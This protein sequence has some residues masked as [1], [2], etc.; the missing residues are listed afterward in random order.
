MHDRT[1]AAVAMRSLP[2]RD[3]RSVIRLL[4]R[5]VV[6]REQ[7]QAK[8]QYLLEGL[9]RIIGGDVWAWTYE[10]EVDQQGGATTLARIAGGWAGPQQIAAVQTESADFQQLAGKPIVGQV[11]HHL[12]LTRQQI[13][14]DEQWYASTYYRTIHEPSGLNDFLTSVYSVNPTLRSVV[15]F[16]RLADREQFG[17]RERCLTHLVISQ[18]D[19]LH[20]AGVGLPKR[21]P[22]L[23]ELSP[24]QREVLL[25][26]LAG[27]GRKQIAR[28]LRLSEHTVTDYLKS[29]H[30]HFE[31]S[32]R[33][34]LLAKFIS[35]ATPTT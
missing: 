10:G 17:D 29:L 5:L 1:I 13:V 23:N 3:V 6:M 27:E 20:R 18:V 33:S 8:R 34:E 24:R 26:L 25:L 12:T 19:W 15:W 16:Y 4:G 21:D 32:T 14:P 11:R 7:P 9:A 22:R 30:K 2:I 28:R 35:G 31:V